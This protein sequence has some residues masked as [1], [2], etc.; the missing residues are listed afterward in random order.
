MQTINPI[1]AAVC[2]HDRMMCRATDELSALLDQEQA[3][4]QALLNTKERIKQ[5]TVAL[6]VATQT[7]RQIGERHGLLPH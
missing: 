7:R 2:L 1:A 4:E 3:L 6:I 5:T